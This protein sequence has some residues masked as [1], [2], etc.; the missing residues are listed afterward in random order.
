MNYIN[1]YSVKRSYEIGFDLDLKKKKKLLI[2]QHKLKA[3]KTRKNCPFSNKYLKH[4]TY[5]K[6]F[7][8]FSNLAASMSSLMLNRNMVSQS[9]NIKEKSS[10]M[11]SRCGRGRWKI[12]GFFNC[13]P[14]YS[15]Q[16]LCEFFDPFPHFLN[17]HM[18]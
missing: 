10:G 7:T 13:L 14:L 4:R 17:F 18:K 15:P 3:K 12:G 2:R 5:N 1:S 6:K 9:S 8:W 11:G 16:N